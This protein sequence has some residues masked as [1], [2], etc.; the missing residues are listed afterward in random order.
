M[1]AAQEKVK[2]ERAKLEGLREQQLRQPV[3]RGSEAYK[4]LPRLIDD[5]YLG[6]AMPLRVLHCWTIVLPAVPA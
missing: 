2:E 5:M 3:R 1:T 6:W 4:A